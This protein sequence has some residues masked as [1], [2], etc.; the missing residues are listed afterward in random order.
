MVI[1]CGPLLL[2]WPLYSLTAPSA[3]RRLPAM[4]AIS[5]EPPSV[6]LRGQVTLE[7][8]FG[9]ELY[10]LALQPDVRLV[11]EIGT[12]YGGG[13]SWCIAS[14]L[15]DSIRDLRKPD[16]WLLTLEMFEEAWEYASRTLK[17]MPATCMRAG[18]VG[19]RGYLRP[20]QLTAEDIQSEHYQLYYER[21]MKLA[22]TTSPV[23]ERLCKAYDFDLVLIDGN[24]YT[25]FAEFEVINR[26]CR[27]RY[28]ALHDTG[29]LKTRLVEAFLRASAMWERLS[30]GADQAGWAVYKA[31]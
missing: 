31:V 6:P 20:D 1:G 7:T 29:T 19:P 21:D 9:K 24:E 2:L 17:S 3:I 8:S 14:G 16:K 28:L 12:W 25:G 4:H 11:L 22:A 30:A 15:R 26:Y 27:P 18:T 13:S 5:N 23:L 10:R